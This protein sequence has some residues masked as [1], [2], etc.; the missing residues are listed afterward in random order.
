M[1]LDLCFVGSGVGAPEAFNDGN[2]NGKFRKLMQKDCL[3]IAWNRRATDCPRHA[4]LYLFSS[5]C[6][7][8]CLNNVR[9]LQCSLCLLLAVSNVYPSDRII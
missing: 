7:V 9:I 5:F 4:A 6:P 1:V 2:A 3:H 8:T